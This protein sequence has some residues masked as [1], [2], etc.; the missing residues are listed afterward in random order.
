[1]H[2]EDYSDDKMEYE[3]SDDLEEGLTEEKVCGI[4][5][6]AWTEFIFQKGYAFIF[7][8]CYCAVFYRVHN[9]AG[10]NFGS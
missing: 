9:Y 4:G 7:Q 5:S 10:F 3:G 6:C 2:E 8:K 1:M